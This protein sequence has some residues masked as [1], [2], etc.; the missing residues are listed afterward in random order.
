MAN[1]YLFR[2]PLLS[3]YILKVR[4][5][6][7]GNP[8][9]SSET[10]ITVKVPKNVP[11]KVIGKNLFMVRE[12]LSSGTIVGKVEATDDV[13]QGEIPKFLFE[14][15]KESKSKLYYRFKKTEFPRFSRTLW[16]NALPR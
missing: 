12:G 4:A 9:L 16:L 10:E 11:P 13:K 3:E 14:L 2:E 7:T 8:G 5:M 15:N 1:D 6:D